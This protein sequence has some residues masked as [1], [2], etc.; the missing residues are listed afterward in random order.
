MKKLLLAFALVVGAATVSAQEIGSVW[1]GG[2]L[3]VSTSK[4]KDHD[5]Q[6]S[7]NIIPEV[8]Y[9]LSENLG[10][11]IKLGYGQ[12]YDVDI[13]GATFDGEKAKQVT[14]NPFVRYSFLKGSIGCLLV[15]TGFGYT[16]SDIKGEDKKMNSFEVGFRPGVAINVTEKIAILGHFGFL[17][18]THDKM[19]DYKKDSFGLNLDMTSF[20]VGANIYF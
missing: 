17:G 8:G 6:T 13:N 20:A 12:R 16:H 19:G 3:G 11:G 14:V 2:S 1:V 5:R 4:V 15:D 9:V 7:F 18:Y 10:M